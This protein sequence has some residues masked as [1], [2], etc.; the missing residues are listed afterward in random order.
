MND[1]DEDGEDGDDDDDENTTRTCQLKFDVLISRGSLRLRFAFYIY[2]ARPPFQHLI[3][4][5]KRKMNS[6]YLS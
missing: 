4:Q 5:K 3:F 6:A 2:E 1:D